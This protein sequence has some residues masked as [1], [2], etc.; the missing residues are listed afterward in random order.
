MKRSQPRTV[1]EIVEVFAEL[2][3][4]AREDGLSEPSAEH[5]RQV[6]EDRGV[7]ASTLRVWFGRYA[8]EWAAACC[9]LPKVDPPPPI[10]LVQSAPHLPT[11]DPDELPATVRMDS[12]LFEEWM[13]A[14]LTRNLEASRP[15]TT[16]YAGVA[17]LLGEHHDRLTALRAAAVA[18]AKAEGRNL[19]PAERMAAVETAAA[20]APVHELEVFVRE[21]LRRQGHQLVAEGDRLMLRRA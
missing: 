18:A 9:D 5:K 14:T 20:K 3:R 12:I 15:G 19:S 2:A 21:Y 11:P 1:S 17:K 10:R 16:G 4:L 8:D 6:C 13:V 7:N